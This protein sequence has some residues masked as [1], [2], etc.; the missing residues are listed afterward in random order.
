[1]SLLGVTTLT[2]SF[3][4]FSKTA[5][6]CSVI[7][8]FGCRWKLRILGI[9]IRSSFL[10]S[11][12]MMLHTNS[13]GLRRNEYG[14]SLRILMSL[15]PCMEKILTSGKS[16]YLFLISCGVFLEEICLK[17]RRNL[18]SLTNLCGNSAEIDEIGSGAI[19]I[20]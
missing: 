7:E 19:A 15:N 3:A 10:I 14:A 6:R 12:F 16:V 2:A 17:L 9:L 11:L 20:P 13:I 1:M 18:R 5:I 8:L 4:T